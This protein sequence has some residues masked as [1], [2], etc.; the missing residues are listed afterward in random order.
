MLHWGRGSE[1]GP[2]VVIVSAGASLCVHTCGLDVYHPRQSD[3]LS[4]SVAPPFE[5][6]EDALPEISAVMMR[7]TAR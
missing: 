5:L 1:A 7:W 3:A 4:A 2:T 6:P